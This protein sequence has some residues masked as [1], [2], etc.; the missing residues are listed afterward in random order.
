MIGWTSVQSSGSETGLRKIMSFMHL[1]HLM[2]RTM[3][4]TKPTIT[5]NMISGVVDAVDGL[6]DGWTYQIME[7][8]ND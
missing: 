4:M 3:T 7:H 2:K 1:K 8:G 6:P 5:I